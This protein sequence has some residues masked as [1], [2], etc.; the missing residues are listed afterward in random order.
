MEIFEI[1]SWIALDVLDLDLMCL[2]LCS[3]VLQMVVYECNG[4]KCNY[5]SFMCQQLMYECNCD[6][7]NHIRL[8]L[9]F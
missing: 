5:V 2:P 8:T 1:M 9:Q 4:Y 7:F 6:T 3:D